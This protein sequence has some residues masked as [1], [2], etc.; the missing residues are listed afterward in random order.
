[1]ECTVCPAGKIQTIP[2]LDITIKCQ[3][4]IGTYITDNGG[5]DT[6]HDSLSDCKSCPAGREFVNITTECRVC[7]AG[8]Y[9]DSND[10]SS[11]SC[12]AC[13]G[14]YITDDGGSNTE[15]VSI[16]NCSSCPA[17]K[18]FVS[19]TTE[20]RVCDAGQYQDS[21]I[22]SS[23]SCTACIGSYI[24]DARKKVTDHDSFLDCTNCSLG[25]EFD[26]TITECTICGA[27]QYQDVSNRSSISCKS[28]PVGLYIDI[29]SRD[30]QCNNSNLV[31][32]PRTPS[33]HDSLDDCK[34]CPIGYEITGEDTTQCHVCGFS[35][36]QDKK[37]VP[38]VKCETCLKDTYIT[39]DN[40]EAVAHDNVKDCV[41]CK[42]GKFAKAGERACDAC[43]AGKEANA[44]SNVSNS[45]C[46]V[47]TAGR[48]SAVETNS[49]CE[50]CPHGFYQSIEGA[51]YCLPCL[52]KYIDR[53]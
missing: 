10:K 53:I 9:Q 50:N 20:C 12:T 33:Q 35:K 21:N 47:C 2:H 18:E 41:A 28:C 31:T 8:Q 15:H 48:Y 4:C 29:A 43:T 17:G 34:T 19:I 51:P 6:E 39:D 49:S 42:K 40:G 30:Q 14:T 22:K 44:A 45:S 32:V 13:I 16:L 37:D 38:N 52:R 46:V 36:Y 25:K 24:L 3:D 27:G 23:P 11:P 26:S 1:L 7:D 5:T